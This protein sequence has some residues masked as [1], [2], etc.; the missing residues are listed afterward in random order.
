MQHIKS[1]RIFEVDILR[2]FALFG[3]FLAHMLTWYSVG[4]LPENII[5]HM[6]MFSRFIYKLNELFISGKFFAL[7]SFLFGLSFFLQIQSMKKMPGHPFIRYAWRITILGFIGLV[8]FTFWL[9]D[10]L[11]IYAL[12]GFLL[13]PTSKLSNRQLLIIGIILVINIPGKMMET[14]HFLFTKPENLNTDYWKAPGKSFYQTITHAGWKELFLFNWDSW[15]DKIRFLIISGRIFITYGFFLLG[16]FAGRKGWFQNLRE[17]KGIFKKILKYSFWVIVFAEIIRILVFWLDAQFKLGWRQELI[18]DFFV[19]ILFNIRTAA[20]ICV[21]ISGL[22]LLT[23]LPNWKGRLV[24]FSNV[25][26]MAITCY[27]SQTVF[28][29]LLFYHVGFGLFG[30]TELWLN[31]LI[32]IILFGL[33]TLFCRIWIKKFNFGPVEWL[34]RSLTYFKWQPISKNGKL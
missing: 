11:S 30:K 32:T 22:T 10:I 9:N 26:K 33:Q 17:A 4:P 18:S 31:W 6:S 2:G 8:H 19:A 5:N 1:N 29:L 21:Y 27:L 34:W 16:I 7:F 3:I 13:I 12:L 23:F 28:G 25:G 24:H 14:V 20:L 15:S